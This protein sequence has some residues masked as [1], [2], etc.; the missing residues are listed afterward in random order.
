MAQHAQHAWHSTRLSAARSVPLIKSH[1]K[2][3]F[4]NHPASKTVF[5][6]EQQQWSRAMVKVVSTITQYLKL[7]FWWKSYISTMPLSFWSTK[8][9]RS[10]IKRI[11]KPDIDGYLHLSIHCL[12]HG[13]RCYE[14]QAPSQS[15]CDIMRANGTFLSDRSTKSSTLQQCMRHAALRWHARSLDIQTFVAGWS[16][17]PCRRSLPL[18]SKTQDPSQASLATSIAQRLSKKIYVTP[19]HKPVY[20]ALA[21][22]GLP[23]YHLSWY[24]GDE[25]DAGVF[26]LP[27]GDLISPKAVEKKI[28]QFIGDQFQ[29][30]HLQECGPGCDESLTCAC[31]NVHGIRQKSEH[32]F[33]YNTT[34]V[35][36]NEMGAACASLVIISILYITNEAWYVKQRGA[37]KLRIAWKTACN[38]SRWS[39]RHNIPR[40]SALGVSWPWNAKYRKN[41][42]GRCSVELRTRF[43]F[44]LKQ[45]LDIFMFLLRTSLYDIVLWIYRC[46]HADTIFAMDAPTVG[47]S[48]VPSWYINRSYLVHE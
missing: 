9:D 13:R 12:W 48:L 23:E 44:S 24:T 41:K 18:R 46:I 21:A 35:R 10:N 17:C 25:D 4:N 29:S 33:V 1:G 7:F 8:R 6:W 34:A 40:M 5:W 31:C 14:E 11:I 15:A 42:R 3:G 22:E 27:R 26:I 16:S 47:S 45:L 43:L 32:G 39:A 28:E 36:G 37:C 2:N 19:A 30:D 20:D 38:K